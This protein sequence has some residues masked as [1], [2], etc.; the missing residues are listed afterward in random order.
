MHILYSL[1]ILRMQNLF[2]MQNSHEYIHIH[3]EYTLHLQMLNTPES[4]L[5]LKTL[6]FCT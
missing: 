2:I 4:L 5:F 6:I 3:F 1:C